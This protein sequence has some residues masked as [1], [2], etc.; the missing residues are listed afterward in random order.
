M[1]KFIKML[2]VLAPALASF[3]KPSQDFSI[4]TPSSHKNYAVDILSFFNIKTDKSNASAYSNTRHLSTKYYVKY[5][6]NWVNKG[7]PFLVLYLIM[8]KTYLQT[9][10]TSQHILVSFKLQ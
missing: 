4:A 3:L 5:Y 1:T 2:W 6:R 9:P 7:L 10:T 8:V